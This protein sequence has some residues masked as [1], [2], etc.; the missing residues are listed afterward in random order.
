MDPVSI[1]ILSIDNQKDFINGSL[2]VKG[3]DRSADNTATMIRGHKDEIDMIIESHDNHNKVHI[4]HIIWYVD[5]MGCHPDPYTYISCE[6]FMS[7]KYR[8]YNPQ[9]Q[10]WTEGYMK[11]T[12]GVMVWPYH[13][14]IGSVGAAVWPNL[15]DAMGEWEDG[16][17]KMFDL[18]K[19]SCPYTEHFSALK[20]A[21]VY[22]GDKKAT[23]MNT[24]FIRMLSKYTHIAIVGQALDFC[25]KHT[26]TDIINE[27]GEDEVSKLWL[28]EDATNEV[29][30]PGLENQGKEFL[31]FAIGKGLNIATTE[32]FFSKIS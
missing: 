15:R 9:L 19:G 31:D 27:F 23:D 26:V 22:P 12:G 16:F 21:V 3:A 2:A 20:A 32:N 17:N 4:A 1:A 14:L 28:L 7:G 6:A 8:C 30:A 10:D 11:K 25:V 18:V 29:K 24:T 5:A 13:C